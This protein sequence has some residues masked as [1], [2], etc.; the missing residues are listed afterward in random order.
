M[1]TT[2]PNAS[3]SGRTPAGAYAL[4]VD[5]HHALLLGNIADVLL[6]SRSHKRS[7][8]RGPAYRVHADVC[9]RIPT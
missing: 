4:G 7:G 8:R 3:L 1:V 6:T 5:Q 9:S 2:H